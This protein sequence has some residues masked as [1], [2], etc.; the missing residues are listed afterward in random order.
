MFHGR[1][2]QAGRL[3]A[4]SM[5]RLVVRAVLPVLHAVPQLDMFRSSRRENVA[6]VQ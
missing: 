4:L 1:E 5:R 3:K 6:A 2:Q